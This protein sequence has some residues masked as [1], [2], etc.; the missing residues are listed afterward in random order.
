MPQAQYNASIL[1][2][3]DTKHRNLRVITVFYLIISGERFSNQ[4]YSHTTTQIG[5]TESYRENSDTRDSVIQF[6]SPRRELGLTT[7]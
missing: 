4:R 2:K 1:I 6:F 5:T 7:Q 3:I